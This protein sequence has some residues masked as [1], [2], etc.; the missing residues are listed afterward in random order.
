VLPEIGKVP[1]SGNLRR[2]ANDSPQQLFNRLLA[3]LLC[4]ES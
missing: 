3:L 4:D 2:A 1:V